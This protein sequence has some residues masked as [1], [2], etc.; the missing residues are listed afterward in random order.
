MSFIAIRMGYEESMQQLDG[1]SMNQS[2]S[3]AFLATLADND[4]YF[5][6][7]AMQQLDWKDFIKATVKEVDD[8]FDTGVW[9]LN[10]H[11]E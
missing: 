3:F 9:R 7:S 2:H 4:T 5:Y 11:S 10:K 8:L 6:S 1:G